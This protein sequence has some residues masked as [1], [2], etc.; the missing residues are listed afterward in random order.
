MRTSIAIA[1]AAIVGIVAS[2][3]A[4][5]VDD[6]QTSQTQPAAALVGPFD[7]T[8]EHASF[9]EVSNI[10]A[11]EVVTHW[12]FWSDSCE[13]LV[14]VW[15]CLTPRDTVVVDPRAI[16]SIDERNDRVGP[17][18]DLSGQRGSVIVT[19]YAPGASC[20]A[21]ADEVIVDDSIVGAFTIADTNTAAAFGGDM[22]GFGLD[23]VDDYVDLPDMELQRLDVQTFNPTTLGDTTIALL[24]L[25]ESSGELQPLVGV[26]SQTIFFDTLEVPTSLPDV[27]VSCSLI[28][29]IFE[30]LLPPTITP[31]SSGFVRL[32][33]P[34]TNDGPIGHDTWLVGLYGQSVGNYGS[35][36]RMKYPVLSPTPIPT[37]SPIVPPTPTPQPSLVPP[38]TFVPPP[39]PT[40]IPTGS[41]IVPPTPTPPGT[42]TPVPTNTPNTTPTPDASPTPVPTGSP[43]VP[44]TPTAAPTNTPAPTPTPAATNTPAPTPTPDPTNTPA[45]TPTPAPTNTSVPTPTPVPTASPPP[46]PTAAP[47]CGYS[48]GG[49]GTTCNGNNPG[50]LRDQEFP[51]A[52]PAG[53]SIGGLTASALWTTSSAIGAYLP[54]GGTSGALSGHLTDPTSTASGVLGGQLVA[55]LLN[56]NIGTVPLGYTLSAACVPA[57][58]AGWTVGSLIATSQTAVDSGTLPA[59]VSFSDLN[60]GLTA[61]NE[62]F[63]EC[64]DDGCV[65]AP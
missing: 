2:D 1:V 34:R 3:A 6:L 28:G 41:P 39:S 40:P 58:V 11:D 50:C 20:R 7:V 62:G 5:L 55:A 21:P 13:H 52:F 54:A 24:A 48:Q 9:I 51:S 10:A 18:V 36:L 16:S 4:G 59:G 61:V 64:V 29:S 53:L 17:G 27:E 33:H 44:P 31:N 35:G 42:P 60:E 57:S 12:V 25:A 37:G 23:E 56:T 45:S 43:I 65:V 47:I 8:E 38:P 49:W 46:T 30:T 22:V 15:I 32:L 26:R 63:D 19:A 14:D